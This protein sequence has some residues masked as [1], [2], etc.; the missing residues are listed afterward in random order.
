MF[1]ERTDEHNYTF[2]SAKI[3]MSKKYIGTN[4]LLYL[5]HGQI[6]AVYLYRKL[7]APQQSDPVYNDWLKALLKDQLVNQAKNV[8]LELFKNVFIL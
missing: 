4:C 2:I 6:A 8:V 1:E 5:F 7:C 3:Y